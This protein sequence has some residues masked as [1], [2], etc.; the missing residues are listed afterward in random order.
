MLTFR[1]GFDLAGLDKAVVAALIDDSNGLEVGHAPDKAINAGHAV[2]IHAQ[3][4]FRHAQ[5]LSLIP[6]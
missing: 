1:G 2:L 4:I 5:P 3:R 6:I